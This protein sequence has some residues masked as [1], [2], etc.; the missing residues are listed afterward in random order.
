MILSGLTRLVTLL[1]A[2]NIEIAPFLG[3]DEQI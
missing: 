3:E 2:N 1:D